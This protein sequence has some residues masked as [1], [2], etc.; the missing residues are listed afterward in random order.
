M[1]VS[2]VV[3]KDTGYHGTL[4]TAQ[5]LAK[6]DLA[7][8][9]WVKKLV[10]LCDQAPQT[11]FEDVQRVL[12]EELGKSFEDLFERFDVKPIGS[13]S[14]AQARSAFESDW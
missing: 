7:P 4:Q 11:P 1:N 5:L 13:A 14:V 10:V 6:P 12:E 9:A 2:F 3:S 8:M